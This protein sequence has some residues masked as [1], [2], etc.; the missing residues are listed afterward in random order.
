MAEQTTILVFAYY[1]YKD[2]VFQSAVL[3][4]FLNFPQKERFKFVFI[5]FEQE[6]F[7]LSHQEK[8]QITHFLR[9]HQIE[10][11]SRRWHSGRFK[12]LKKIYD[13]VVG[14]LH[15]LLVIR[16]CK[17]RF[18]YSEGFPGAI[19]GHYLSKIAGVDHIVH[20]FE[21]H[22]DY[23][24]ESG[25]W[26]QGSWETRLL[27]KYQLKIAQQ[28]SHIL[29]AT[30]L[31][32]QETKAKLPEASTVFLRVPSC[33]D[34]DLFKFSGQAR[35]RIR[36]EHGI[37]DSDHVFVYLGKIGGMYFERELYEFFG[38]LQQNIK[39]RCFFLV[40]TD[41][42][43][44]QVLQ[45]LAGQGIAPEDCLVKFVNK[46]QVPDY[47]SASDW[48]FCG[49]KPIP[50]RR[51][52]SPIKNGEYWAC[53]LPVIIPAGIS[54]DYLWA[55]DAGIGVVLREVSKAGFAEVVHQI[56]R[57]DLKGHRQK[58]RNFVEQD[59]SIKKYQQV[60]LHMFLGKV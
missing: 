27:K 49:I 46:E 29:T 23:M 45:A 16:R 18:I 4:Y 33:V 5:T 14:I 36:Q 1:S 21:P 38:Y 55:Q 32:I 41:Q 43:A 60:Y 3:P 7:G 37:G 12:A 24:V 53:G 58:A 19:L 6:R 26:S 25:I 39:S 31:M 13:F 59:R 57:F 15:A 48:A 17:P 51:Y 9:A 44:T 30:D 50:S 22:A 10:W 8:Q 47:L 52:S 35:H 54:D 56:N 28:A 20:T 34:L 40:L 11:I 2:P 42:D